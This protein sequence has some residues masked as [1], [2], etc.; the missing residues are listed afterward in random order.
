MVGSFEA[1]AVEVGDRV[2]IG[3]GAGSVL[4]RQLDILVSIKPDAFIILVRW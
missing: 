4:V 1:G 3:G 2:G